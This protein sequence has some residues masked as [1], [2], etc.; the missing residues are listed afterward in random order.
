MHFKKCFLICCRMLKGTPSQN[1][2]DLIS[3]LIYH[4][5]QRWNSNWLV[6]SFICLSLFTLSEAYS[7][8][9]IQFYFSVRKR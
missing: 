3:F 8:V 2:K 4:L 5:N 6:T 9:L 1:M 7:S